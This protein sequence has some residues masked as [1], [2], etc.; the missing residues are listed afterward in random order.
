MSWREMSSP[1]MP[2]VWLAAE[3]RGVVRADL[4]M[5]LRVAK[6]H[7]PAG[8]TVLAAHRFTVLARLLGDPAEEYVV[9]RAESQET[10]E[11]MMTAL[12]AEIASA[13]GGHKDGL[14]ELGPGGP[15][16]VRL[17]KGMQ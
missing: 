1:G 7:P 10:A 9:G 15:K 11:Q 8:T 6:E 13:L 4:V 3:D 16:L 2:Q 14:I 12:L 5:A 17:S